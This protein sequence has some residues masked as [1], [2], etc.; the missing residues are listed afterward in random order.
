MAGSLTVCPLLSVHLLAAPGVAERE[1][2]EQD[3][4]GVADVCDNGQDEETHRQVGVIVLP[5]IATGTTLVLPQGAGT[6][7]DGSKE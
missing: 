4:E 3:E 1:P 2:T 5:A 6:V 7:K